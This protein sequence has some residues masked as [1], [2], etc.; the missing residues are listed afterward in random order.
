MP[1]GEQRSAFLPSRLGAFIVRL[2]PNGDHVIA[3]T[4]ALELRGLA[5]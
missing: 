4:S 3:R 2:V 5:P 1:A